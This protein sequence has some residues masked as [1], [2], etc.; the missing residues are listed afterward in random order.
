MSWQKVACGC[1]AFI[2][3]VP[4]AIGF[5]AVAVMANDAA[6]KANCTTGG[7][8]VD[9]AAV[10]AQVQQIL[11]GKGGPTVP[12]SGLDEPTTQI[13][14]AKAIVATGIA[15]QVPARG[16]VIALATALQESGLQNLS[17][18]DRDSLGLFQQRPSQGWGTPA[19]LQ[20]PVYASTAFY[21]ALL[22][23]DGWQQ[24]PL[25]EAAQAVQKSGFPDAYAKWE[26]LANALQQ[27]ISQ[28]LGGSS[29]TPAPSPS[30]GSPPPAATWCGTGGSGI[31]WGTIPPG[32]LPAGYVIPTDAPPAVQSA[33]RYALGQLGTPYQW[34]G[35]CT[36]PHGP[37]PMGR[38]D[39]SSLVQQSYHAGGITLTRTTYTQVSEGTAISVDALKP[40]DLLFTE[41][42]PNGPN[43]VGMYIGQGLVVQAPHTGAVVDV[44]SLASWRSAIVAA[45]RIVP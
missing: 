5:P 31:D 39:C 22:Q 14:N 18:G 36:A 10:A 4:I 7:Q 24:L 37:D 9:V 6:I 33:I 12:V 2:L 23:V 8:Q 27:A 35:S 42:G 30:P 13:P 25:T 43:H 44:T 45:R 28:A 1:A 20:D 32:T 19:Q 17:Y 3:G 34:G 29:A 26:S 38:C 11:S 40:G 15:M 16:Q 21:K 41:P